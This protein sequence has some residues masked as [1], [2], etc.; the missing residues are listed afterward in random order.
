MLDLV[1]GL[2][3]DLQHNL[4]RQPGKWTGLLARNLRAKAIRG[5]N[6]IEGYLVSEEAALSALDNER[7]D[8]PEVDENAWVNV[9]HYREALDYIV[10]LSNEKDFSYS[11]ALLK[12]LHF[13]MMRHRKDRNP[14]LYRAGPIFVRDE[15]T[16]TNV[17]EGPPAEDVSPLVEM[18]C[19]ALSDADADTSGRLIRAAMAHLNLVMIHPFSDGNGRMARALQTLVLSR[20]R[21]FDPTFSSIEEYLGRNHQAYYDVLAKVGQGKWKPSNSASPWIRFCLTAHYRQGESVKRRLERISLLFNEVEFELKRRALP[22]RA[23]Q[24]LVNAA[25]GYRI[26]NEGYRREADVSMASASRDLKQLVDARL[27][28][29]AGEKRG[30]HYK[31]GP[32]LTSLAA[33]HERRAPIPDPFHLV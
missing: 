16:G 14:G 27:I 30:R 31:P 9:V 1:R 5:S 7:L 29:S 15:E 6:S 19:S 20:G 12:A 2:W 26:R 18:L 22:E 13:M 33:E 10:Q 23:A 28:V 32:W 8:D 21:I 3:T 11:P 17:Y 4:R 25:L 24:S